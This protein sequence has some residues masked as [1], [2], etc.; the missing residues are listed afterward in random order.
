MRDRGVLIDHLEFGRRL[1]A[2]EDL[3]ATYL[4]EG[5]PLH[6]VYP[7]SFGL[8][9]GP[10]SLLGER[11]AR[12]AWGILQVTALW[13][14]GRL[15][16]RWIE[17][18][19]PL[20]S[21]RNGKPCERVSESRAHWVLALTALLASRYV[22]RDTHG[23]GGNLINLAL[24]L[25]AFFESESGRARRA[26]L[27]LGAS[28]ATKPTMVLLLP[29]F[30]LTRRWSVVG[31]GGLTALGFVGVSLAVHGF[32]TDPFERW[33]SGVFAL[34]QQQDV[35]ADPAYGLPP[36]EWM[37]QSLRCAVGRVAGRTPDDLASE[38]PG[39]VQ[40][41]G[42]EPAV[43]AWVTRGLTL[44][45]LAVLFARIFRTRGDF[46]GRFVGFASVLALSLLLSPISWK[47]HHTA[48]VPAFALLA[49]AILRGD[50][51]A[52]ALGLGYYLVCTA[53]GGDLVGRSGKMW[54]QAHYL[55]TLGALAMFA[56][57]GFT[58][59]GRGVSEELS[60]R[61]SGLRPPAGR[62]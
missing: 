18:T 27:W 32:R 8:L 58:R 12:I 49:A 44:A 7:P 25:T 21:L 55:T 24:V 59:V 52:L 61:R 56:W 43:V 33:I 1:F 60:D 62:S 3:Y 46:G 23:G 53:G 17:R 22:L 15:L 42:L 37:N 36:F 19:Q 29:F 38:V 28:L 9:T 14:I 41:F 45:F 26:G 40:G 34:S 48:L 4:D 54:Q 39:F 16:L 31:W 35:F 2:G 10:F 30:V 50:R 5:R 51:R 13:Q 6:P 57:L 47:A 20:S 11:L